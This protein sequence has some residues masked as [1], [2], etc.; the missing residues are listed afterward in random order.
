ML[1]LSSYIKDELNC[2]EFEIQT[3]EAK[4]VDYISQPDHKEI[5]SVLKNKYTKE[6]KERL[7]KLTREEVLEYL[8]NGNITVF[9]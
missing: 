6:L 1:T 8:T 5:G 7:N 4:Y 9:E 3:N 2:I